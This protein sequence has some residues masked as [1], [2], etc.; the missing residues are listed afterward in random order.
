VVL[1]R[2]VQGLG[3]HARGPH[4]EHAA[5]R[6]VLVVELEPDQ[7]RVAIGADG[8]AATL[9]L[10]LVPA[11]ILVAD[12]PVVGPVVLPRTQFSHR[13][14]S[15]S[16]PRSTWE[17]QSFAS[18]GMLSSAPAAHPWDTSGQANY[19]CGHRRATVAAAIYSNQ[20]PAR[21]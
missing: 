1:D 5:R 12:R 15:S 4:L 13:S 17:R 6:P 2:V 9:V 10:A 8:V 21:W 11:R 19:M 18:L 20:Q 3:H 16:A 7:R 14:C